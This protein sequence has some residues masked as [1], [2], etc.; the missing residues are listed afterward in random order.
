MFIAE[1]LDLHGSYG[2]T[3]AAMYARLCGAELKTNILVP[4]AAAKIWHFATG[5]GPGGNLM[6]GC[7]WRVGASTG[8]LAVISHRQWLGKKGSMGCSRENRW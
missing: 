4:R 5:E 1:V 8:A 6:R 7:W 2:Q 3:L